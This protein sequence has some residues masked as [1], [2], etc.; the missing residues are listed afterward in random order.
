MRIAFIPILFILLLGTV[1]TIAQT[2]AET[3]Y[4]RGVMRRMSGDTAGAIEDYTKA[5]EIDPKFASAY[6][7]RGIARYAMK[8]AA[9][10]IQDYTKAIELRPDFSDAYG[11]RGIIYAESG[12]AKT[13]FAD[14]DMA[15][16]LKPGNP[17]TYNS[18]GLAL[19]E[20]GKLDEA[21]RDYDVAIRLDPK[22]VVALHNRGHARDLK[23]DFDLA[24]A[25]YTSALS[26]DPTYIKSL[27][28]RGIAYHRRGNLAEAL[29]DY[30]RAL[31]LEP[32][33]PS[34]HYNRAITR[35]AI[36]D[37]EGAIDDYTR[38][39]AVQHLDFPRRNVHHGRGMAYL[40]AQQHDKALADFDTFVALAPDDALSYRA[41]GW[42]KLCLND[43]AGAYSDSLEALKRLAPGTSDPYS[44]IVGYLGLMKAGRSDDASEFIASWLRKNRDAN[45]ATQVV[46]YF[47]GELAEDKLLQLANDTGTRTELYTYLGERALFRGDVATARRHFEWV[48]KNGSKDY[49]EYNLAV[50][51]LRRIDGK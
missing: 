12:N 33:D 35:T 37:F 27:A 26:I 48:V 3:F 5:I 8:D 10:A 4:N 51:D 22:F 28:N 18:R 15:I 25:D 21:I 20:Q 17:L 43:G 39:L 40:K 49:L 44:V 41:R 31:E 32:G 11:N 50:A 16:K 36:G 47:N 45:W 6:Y 42:V 30:G 9:G 13:A 2:P 24:I 38:T 7:N 14:F 23:R 29:A 1:Q 46:R 34:H 19:Q